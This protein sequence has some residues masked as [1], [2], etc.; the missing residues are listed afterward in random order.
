MLDYQQSIEG[1]TQLIENDGLS[2]VCSVRTKQQ[3]NL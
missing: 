2:D 3:G 1:L